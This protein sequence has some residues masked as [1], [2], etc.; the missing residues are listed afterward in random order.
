MDDSQDTSIKIKHR[1]SISEN[2]LFDPSTHVNIDELKGKK[3]NSG[4]LIITNLAEKDLRE[5]KE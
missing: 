1:R 2:E 5:H 4:K 3:Y